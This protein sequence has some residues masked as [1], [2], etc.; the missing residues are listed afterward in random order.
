VNYA[1]RLPDSLMEHVRRLARRDRVSMNQFM[2]TAIAEKTSALD[3]EEFFA[4]RA[5]RGSRSRALAV[6]RKVERR[7]NPALPGDELPSGAASSPRQRRG[8]RQVRR[9]RTRANLPEAKAMRLAVAETRAV[10]RG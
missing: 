5:A 7:D 8:G 4:R 2:L 9:A 10:R 1:L 6:L 3:T